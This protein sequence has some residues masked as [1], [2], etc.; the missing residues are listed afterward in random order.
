MV[1]VGG[2]GLGVATGAAEAG[3]AA[4]VFG[5]IKIISAPAQVATLPVASWIAPQLPWQDPGG[6]ILEFTVLVALYHVAKNLLVVGAQYAHHRIVGESSAALA[7]T[8]LR[9][10]LLAPYPFHFRRNSAEL[11]RNT[12][13]SVTAVFN[14][15]GAAAAVLSEL[16]VGVAIAAVLLAAAPG[17]TL[18][19]GVVLAGLIALVLR[20]TRRLARRAGRE[21]STSSTGRC[22]RRCS[23]RSARS[24]RSRRSGASASSTALTPMRSAGCSRSAISASPWR[25]CRRW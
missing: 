14:A 25:R 2:S 13:Y 6:V 1:V 12:T 17:A 23:R 24:R 8:M 15:L 19:V 7:C 22:C 21:T 5:L 4:A 9:G 11:I 3:A 18:I 16:L 20:S 10:Y